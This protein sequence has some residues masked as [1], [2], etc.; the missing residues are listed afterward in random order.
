MK[1]ISLSL[2]GTDDLYA[3]GAVANARLART[4][5]PDWTMRVYCSPEVPVIGALQSLGVDVRVVSPSP[6]FAGLFWRFLPAAETDLD[7]VIVR[8]ADSRLNMRERRAVDAWIASGLPC[9][10]M[11]DHTRHRHA[12]LLG[13]MWGCRGGAIPDMAERVARFDRGANKHED[14]QFLRDEI[15]PLVRDRCLVHS[16]VPHPLGG[17]PFPAHPPAAGFVG[18]IVPPRSE[19]S[20]VMALLLPSRGRPMAAASVA[21][22]AREMAGT[23]AALRIRVGVEPDE[24]ASYRAAFGDDASWIHVLSSGGNYVRAIRELHAAVDADI[25]GF[26]ADDFVFETEGWDD[27]VRDAVADLPRRVGLV[28]G[29]DG[30]QHERLAT[31]P[32]VTAEWI[33]TIGDA[34]PGDY[35]HMFCDADLTDVARQAGL[36]HFLGD[37]KITHRHYVNGQA[38]RDETYERSSK[39]WNAG[40]A[41]FDRRRPER[42]R[43]ARR[44]ARAARVLARLAKLEFPSPVERRLLV[45]ACRHDAAAARAWT[46][47]IEA[48]G[49]ARAT[50]AC[51]RLFPLAWWN[52]QRLGVSGPDLDALKPD[53]RSSWS[54][55]HTH[56]AAAAAATRRLGDA[57]IPAVI[58]GGVAIA[59]RYY[60]APPLRPTRHVTLMVPAASIAH[61]RE[62]VAALVPPVASRVVASPFD[63]RAWPLIDDTWT[64]AEGATIGGESVRMLSP[65]DE[66][67]RVCVGGTRRR[68]IPAPHWVADLLAIAACA[69]DQLDWS[70][71]VRDARAAHVSAH[72]R[73]A[74]RYA[75]RTLDLPVLQ[76]AY[77]RFTAAATMPVA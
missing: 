13:G 25:Y 75:N 33:A 11:R 20:A 6:R 30:L 56:L 67:L 9:H 18:R 15:W 69:A 26:A 52:L 77:D 62:I 1:L 50:A 2:W 68:W 8:D 7:Y 44:A 40:E 14:T 38:P 16:S 64:R 66:L 74:L 34:L 42:R 36:L 43:L 4:I 21:R 70:A 39:T 60:E 46:E 71:L 45:A 59:A 63:R 53:Y 10:A 17:E 48:G 27:R 23:P 29:D 31:A 61:A 37:L 47:W 51:R 24:A 19:S 28:Y 49:P 65:T 54:R 35:A 5:Y 57:G 72:V 3:L 73:L 76:L 12:P 32:F 55:A 41:E 22:Q 58:I